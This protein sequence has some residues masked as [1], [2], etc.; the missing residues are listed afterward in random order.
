VRIGI[1]MLA[2]QSPGSRLRGIGRLGHNLAATLLACDPVNEYVL[3]TYEGMPTDRVPPSPR[4]RVHM[5][6]FEP[7]DV[8]L[9]NVIDR[10]ARTNPDDLDALLLLSPMELYLAYN[11]PIKPLNG[12]LMA[13]VVHDVIPFIFQERYLNDL[14]WA[15]PVYRGLETLRKYDVLLS[16]SDA[17][18]AD[19]LKLL[20]LHDESVVTISCASEEGFFAPD[21]SEPMSETSASLLRGL[22]IDRPF[23]F[24]LGGM[25]ELNDR[26]NLFGLVDAFA[27][28]PEPLRRSHQL[29]LS[30]YMSDPFMA[31]LRKHAAERGV[32]AELV[33][34][35]E[36]PDTTL[37]V[38]FQRC[39]AFA[40]P[41]L[42]EGFGLPILE[43]MQCGAPVVAGNNSSQVE[44]VGE[45]GLL[46]NAYDPADIASK[47][48]RVL[49]DAALAAELGERALEQARRF[50]WPKT[51][52]KTIAAIEEAYQRNSAAPSRRLHPRTRKLR[53]DR[54]HTD[55][56]RIAIF[57]PFAPK[58]SGISDYAARLVHQL[59]ADYSIDLYHEVG[60]I[61][62]LGLGSPE[63]GCHDFRLFERIATQ[64]NYSA[65][66]Y[67][68]GNSIYHRFV[69]A[70]LLRH[71]GIVTL[72]DFCLTNFT[73]WFAHLPGALPGM[74]ENEVRHNCPLRAE[75][76]LAQFPQW[77]EEFGGI[78]V[79]CARRGLW[80]NKRVLEAATRV[81]LHSPWCVRQVESLFPELRHRCSIIPMGATP[82]YLAPEQKAA[83]RARFELA[84]DALVCGSFGILTKG[85]MNN[86]ALDAFAALAE[87]NRRA[88]FV[89]AGEDWEKGETKDYAQRLGI[90]NRVRFLG[91]QSAADF[92]DLIAITDIGVSLRL[93]PTNGET[94]ASLLDLLCAGVPTIV[95]DVATFSDY[96]N[97]VVRKVNWERE[98]TEGLRLA[99]AELASDPGRRA[100]LG[101]AAR[102]YV[103]ENH[104]WEHSAALY[105]SL[106]EQVRANHAAPV[107]R[108]RHGRAPRRM[109]TVPRLAQS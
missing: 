22:G 104:R 24:N 30:C 6:R 47:L 18:R 88:V 59:K 64:V 80:L 89:F 63:F 86:E 90:P 41:S 93:P 95:T 4:A 71:P 87:S 99:L 69:Y 39:A 36:V 14:H 103:E 12:L 68:M 43:A 94:S 3:Y 57:S 38:L 19:Y 84:P 33:L 96:P 107:A 85:K 21:R 34:T 61:P 27:I 29:V 9:H 51:A 106:M 56:P 78:P 8:T 53:F 15:V 72:H 109:T 37:R 100:Q 48:A 20:G 46:A 70:M 74:F 28:I 108:R 55:R 62:E 101:S 83:I 54:A 102:R 82:R 45:A 77:S 16:N 98:G 23:V 105:R 10:L 11:P 58:G 75:E 25:D 17:T 5:L 97:T 73:Y 67:Q 2:V 49:S 52:A 92:A 13:A 60:Y 65:I 31:R 76:Y 79:A 32:D 50:S 91:R 7:G 26:K 44:V 42:Y 81:V 35:N 1:D 40:F 66:L